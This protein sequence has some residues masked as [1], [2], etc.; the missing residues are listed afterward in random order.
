[1]NINKFDTL[2]TKLPII[3]FLYKAFLTSPYFA[4]RKK[5]DMFEYT[6]FDKLDVHSLLVKGPFIAFITLG[7]WSTPIIESR[8]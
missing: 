7:V 1:M 5:V 2:K 3:F 8:V 4:R 6:S